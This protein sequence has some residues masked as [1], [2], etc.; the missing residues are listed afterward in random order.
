MNTFVIIA[1]I[2]PDQ[3]NLENGD[4]QVCWTISGLFLTEEVDLDLE[5]VSRNNRQKWDKHV[6]CGMS[7]FSF[8]IDLKT[9]STQRANLWKSSEG[10]LYCF[11]GTNCGCS[12]SEL[13]KNATLIGISLG[14]RDTWLCCCLKPLEVK[15]I[16][17]FW[18]LWLA[19]CDS[20]CTF[21]KHYL[22]V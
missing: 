17:L 9:V 14:N 1:S 18:D 7:S 11:R 16:V 4:G 5:R 20:M 8:Y 6:I 13:F 15:E 2:S 19:V 21:W 10:I 3:G 12:C 22:Y